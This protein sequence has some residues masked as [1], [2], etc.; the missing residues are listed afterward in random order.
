MLEFITK[1]DVCVYECLYVLCWFIY[2]YIYLYMYTYIHISLLQTFY[3]YICLLPTI[4]Y[5][6]HAPTIIP[7]YLPTNIFIHLPYV[8]CFWNLNVLEVFHSFIHIIYLYLSTYV[9]KVIEKECLKFS[10]DVLQGKEDEKKV[11]G[12]QMMI[13]IIY[14]L[15]DD[16]LCMSLSYVCNIFSSINDCL[17]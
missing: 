5:L 17:W 10:F 6:F 12:G 14:Y 9:F 2:I 7:T 15:L 4:L 3:L 16:G 8:C 13:A 11:E 1:L